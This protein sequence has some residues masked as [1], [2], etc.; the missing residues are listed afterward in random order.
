MTTKIDEAVAHTAL[1]L[2][3]SN[4]RE[5]Q[6]EV[7]GSYVSGK[8]CIWNATHWLRDRD[9]WTNVPEIDGRM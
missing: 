7:V 3:Y 4:F 1:A 2:G 9:R 6:V 8:Q 5:K